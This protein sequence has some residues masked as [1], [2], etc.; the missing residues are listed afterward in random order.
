M[1]APDYANGI[2]EWDTSGMLPA[3]VPEAPVAR[4]RSPYVVSLYEVAMRFGHTGPRRRL[5]IGLLD[6]R[7]ELH[8]AGLTRGF[9]WLNGS[10]VENVEELRERQAPADIDV[11]TFFYIPNGHT[12]QSLVESFPALFDG[13]ASKDAY[14]IDAYFV[15]LNQ[16]TSEEIIGEA[17]Y[18]YSLWSHTRNGRWKGYLQ[19]ALSGDDD[20]ETRYELE[21]T[22]GAGG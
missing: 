20:A 13:K 1:P 16:T 10:F 9:Q 18:W 22:D 4:E 5:L 21:R 8:R 3:S 15:Q 12:A 7:A 11:V 17:T 2:P 19:V 6:F 14:A